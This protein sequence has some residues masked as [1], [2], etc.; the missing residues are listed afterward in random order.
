MPPLQLAFEEKA[1][2]LPMVTHR[3]GLE[4]ITACYMATSRAHGEVLINRF[5]NR[6]GVEAPIVSK[7]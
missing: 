4:S 3:S 2:K 6:D 5:D 1:V 7:S